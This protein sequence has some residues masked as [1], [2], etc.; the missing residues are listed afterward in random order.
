M[1][2][3]IFDDL[4]EEPELI[5]LK[6]DDA[7]REQ[8]DSAVFEGRNQHGDDYDST[9]DYLT[10]M[11]K[12]SAIASELE[13]DGLSVLEVPPASNFSYRFYQDFRGKVDYYRTILR[14]RHSRRAQGYSVRFDQKT[15]AKLTHYI[16]QIREVILV[17]EVDEWKK[18]SLLRCL[19]NLQLEVDKDRSKY[20][21]FGAFV[22]EAAGVFGEGG[23]RAEP[24]RKW[25]DSIAGLI[26]GARHA[27]QTPKLAAP[28]KPKQIQPPKTMRVRNPMDDEI[29]F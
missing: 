6:L 14:L 8:C 18:E 16:D 22:V 17:L 2:E 29:P 28:S 24:V 13:L 15:K 20:E 19:N 7:F 12:V 5:F 25:I 3:N 10:Y 11:R 1:A 4:P 27:E 21:V 9:G 26:W 23:R